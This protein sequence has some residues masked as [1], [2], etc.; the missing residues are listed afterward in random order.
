LHE[1][2]N[3]TLDQKVSVSDIRSV[4]GTIFD[5]AR[6]RKNEQIVFIGGHPIASNHKTGIHVA[7]EHLVENAIY[8]LNPTSQFQQQELHDLK[9]V[10]QWTKCQLLTLKPEEHDVM[11]S[12][13]SHF[14][15]L[16]ASSLV[17][18]A[19]KWE[20]IHTYLPGLAAGGFRD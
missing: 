6:E 4:K 17:H 10:L 15:H 18:Q 16:I 9:E 8:V 13:I 12:V 5:V 11:T 3:I 14:P 1:L 19:K 7:K 20:E 2:D